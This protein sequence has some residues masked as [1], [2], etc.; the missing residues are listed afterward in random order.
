MS[1]NEHATAPLWNSE[2]LSVQNAVGEPIPEFR[3]PSEEGAKVPSA[4]RRQDS[5]DVLPYQP[6]GPCAIS[7]P[8]VFEGQ[9]AT[10]VSQSASKAGDREGLAGRSS[11]KKV[12]WAILIGS[13]RG[14]IAVTGRVRIMVLEQGARERLDLAIRSGFPSERMPGDGCGLNA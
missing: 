2:E 13:D 5:G 14:E 12:N 9:V 7:K 8:E 3:Q 4:V 1:D 11:D 6:S 10:L